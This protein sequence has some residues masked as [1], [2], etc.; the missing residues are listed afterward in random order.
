MSV[1]STL[2]GTHDGC[3]GVVL[4]RP[5]TYRRELLAGETVVLRA[6]CQ[7]CGADLATEWA[8][9]AAAVAAWEAESAQEAALA[10]PH[11]EEQGLQTAAGAEG[12]DGSMPVH[13]QGT[14]HGAP[15]RTPLGG[16]SGASGGERR[17]SIRPATALGDFRL[18]GAG[19]PEEAAHAPAPNPEM[20]A[21]MARFS[22]RVESARANLRRMSTDLPSTLAGDGDAGFR[23]PQLSRRDGLPPS[24]LSATPQGLRPAAAAAAPVQ[25]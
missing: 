15:H 4:F 14:G 10:L 17:R 16:G 11:F 20:D 18:R 7:T 8:L 12:W 19:E 6:T 21:Y 2:Q 24:A 22:T 5:A 1:P 25:P 3:G 13:A 23:S 9:P